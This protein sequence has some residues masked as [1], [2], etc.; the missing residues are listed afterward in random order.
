V[1]AHYS[2]L[3]PVA[4]LGGLMATDLRDVTTDLTALDSSGRWAMVVTYEGDAVCA[5]F[6]KWQPASPFDAVS[7]GWLGP[8]PEAWSTSLDRA[9]YQAGVETVREAI[10]RG[11]VY[12]AN[13]C[14][15]RSAKLPDA[16]RADVAALHLL[17]QHGNKA[18]FGGV[19]RV[20]NAHVATASPELFLRRRGSI[21]ESSPIKGT[22]KT[23]NDLS[24]KDRSENIMIVDLVR[25]DLSMVCQTG[26][27]TVPALLHLEQHPGLV[28]LVS[29]VRGELQVDVGWPEIFAATYP[30]GSVTGA[31]KSSAVGI[32]RDIEGVPRGPYC[33]AIGWVDADAGT[34]ELAVGIRTFW[35]AE[36]RV[37]F[38]TG[39]G[40]TWDSDPAGEWAECELKAD[41]LLHVAAG[42]WQADDS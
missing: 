26:S 12:Q 28:H 36:D 27:I 22:G 3:P 8:G 2:D 16:S 11:D 31:P 41:R 42:T 4:R 7:A 25:N 23:A 33:G 21:I 37:W 14:Q 20:S 19:V 6:D 1:G 29:T 40:I 5:R 15:V 34:A 10:S 32:L 35:L 13:V 9:A 38:G 39:A 30:P 18:P 24:P 17:L